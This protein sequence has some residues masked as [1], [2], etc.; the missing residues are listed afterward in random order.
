LDYDSQF[1][2]SN[3]RWR[4]KFLSEAQLYA[5][6][7]INPVDNPDLKIL[8]TFKK[9]GM[10]DECNGVVTVLNWSKRQRSEGYERVK[11]FRKRQSNA[12][13]TDREKEREKER[14]NGFKKPFKTLD[15]APDYKDFTGLGG[16]P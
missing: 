11:E 8:E 4:N 6:S 13:V 9:K 14:S 12:N 16:R 7:G 3:R 1:G 10:I 15:K 5:T 2:K